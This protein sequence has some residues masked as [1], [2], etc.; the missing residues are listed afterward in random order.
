MFLLLPHF[1]LISILLATH[2]ISKPLAIG[3]TDPNKPAFEIPLPKE[4]SAD[5]FANLQGIQNLMG[6]V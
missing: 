1:I 3:P 4:G 5:W 2:D 6:L